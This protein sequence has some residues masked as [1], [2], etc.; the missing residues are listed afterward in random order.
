MQHIAARKDGGTDLRWPR[1][2]LAASHLLDCTE[3]C[4]PP[5][6]VPPKLH[7][8]RAE[9]AR[10]I[11]LLKDTK[12]R[13]RHFRTTAGDCRID[14]EGHEPLRLA[15]LGRCTGSATADAAA[16]AAAG[17]S[18]TVAAG[19]AF[20][21]TGPNPLL[22][23]PRHGPNAPCTASGWQCMHPAKTAVHGGIEI[24]F[25]ALS[26][27]DTAFAHEADHAKCHLHFPS[28]SPGAHRAGLHPR[29]SCRRIGNHLVHRAVHVTP[30]SN[31]QV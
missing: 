28:G 24:Q 21:L 12:V 29:S 30:T 14:F 10:S 8:P 27:H 23:C 18:V 15:A 19:I 7:R 2:A 9:T 20:V 22:P 11:P 16:T 17:G 6:A 3:D 25:I 1:P 4:I 5:L 31:D 13:T 26:P